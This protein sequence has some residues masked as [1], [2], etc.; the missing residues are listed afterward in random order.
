MGLETLSIA[1][2]SVTYFNVLEEMIYLR[3]V[4]FGYIQGFAGAFILILLVVWVAILIFTVFRLINRGVADS[5]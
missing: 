2:E 1:G 5:I 3:D 4:F